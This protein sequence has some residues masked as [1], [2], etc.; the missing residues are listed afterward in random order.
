VKALAVPVLSHRLILEPEAEFTGTT[1]GAIIA[2]VLAEVAPPV[3]SA[4]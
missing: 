2:R 1:V 3:A 4:R